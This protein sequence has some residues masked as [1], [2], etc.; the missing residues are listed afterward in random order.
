VT[1]RSRSRASRNDSR[2][3]GCR[4][5]TS[6]SSCRASPR[7]SISCNGYVT[8]PTASRSPISARDASATSA[9][10]S[11]RF[12]GWGSRASKRSSS[13]SD[14]SPRSARRHRNRSRSS[15]ASARSSPRQ[16]TR[17]SH[18]GE[19]RDSVATVSGTNQTQGEVL[20][21]T[22]MSGPGRSTAADA[23]EDHGW[24]VVD[25]RPRQMRRPLPELAGRSA[26]KL[27]RIAAVVDV[28]GGEMFADLAQIVHQLREANNLRIVFLDASDDA[29][30]RR[31]EQVRRPHPLQ[32]DGTILDGIHEERRQVQAIRD[33][34]DVT[35]DTSNLNVHQL[36]NRIADLVTEDGAPRH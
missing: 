2:N 28:R 30:V 1:P 22:G 5:T 13:T 8:R 3:S 14:P 25:N 36:A 24:Y 19:R 17:T 23:L 10:C 15:P 26:G 6:P 32:A 31:F 20:I 4:T 33:R 18:A 16:S 35:I 12:P 9:R 27:P 7:R 34:A 21:V 29:L 11:P